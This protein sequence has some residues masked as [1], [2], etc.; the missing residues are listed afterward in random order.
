MMRRVRSSH[1]FEPSAVARRRLPSGLVVAAAL[2]GCSPPGENPAPGARAATPSEPA[3]PA[4]DLH[5]HIGTQ[6]SADLV[7]QLQPSAARGALSAADA[8]AALD[9]AGIERAL[10][11]S[12]GYLFEGPGAEDLDRR[13]L[14]EA[15]NDYVAAEVAGYPDRLVG[16]C[17]M[18]PLSE[19]AVAEIARCA[20]E[21]GIRVLKLHFT[22][23]GVDLRSDEHLTQLGRVW[24][25][26]SARGMGAIVHMRTG[27]DDYGAP[28]VRAFIGVLAQFPDVPIHIAHMAGW[29]GYDEWTDAA[30]AE[31]A[32][33]LGDGRLE[34]SGLW[35]G[36]GA[37][38]FQPAA[39]GQDTARARMI[40][41]SNARLVERIRQLGPDRVTYATDWPSWPPVPDPE[42]GIAA[43]V[44]L[45]RGVLSLEPAELSAIFS[46][47]GLLER[48]GR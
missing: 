13:A 21:L 8:I 48:Y 44:R 22:N 7:E 39:A 40:E 17:S 25:A 31:F 43:N 6:T 23:S 14:L 1:R 9:A 45:I 19:Y 20:E 10:V 36:L 26:M 24:Q 37:V 29:G 15:E 38:V 3:P 30:L 42:Q 27:A 18:N 47:A 46:N 35:F 12:L 41:E 11:L 33:A 16:T 5:V 2:I 32:A 4:A 34:S 28:D